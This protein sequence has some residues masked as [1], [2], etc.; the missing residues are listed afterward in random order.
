M[1]TMPELTTTDLETVLNSNSHG[2]WGYQAG[3]E[4]IADEA[5]IAAADKAVL[6]VANAHGWDRFDLFE[7]TNSTHGRHFAD[8]AYCGRIDTSMIHR[9]A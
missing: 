8:D 7:W 6:E 3:R 2:G 5:T 9:V 4:D 1:S